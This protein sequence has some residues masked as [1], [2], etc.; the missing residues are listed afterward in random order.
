MN[1]GKFKKLL[2][3]TI[4]QG[5]ISLFEEEEES[6]EEESEEEESEEEP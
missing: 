4:S 1:N 3:E 2:K 6:E 5:A